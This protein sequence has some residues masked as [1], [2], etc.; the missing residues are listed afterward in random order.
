VCCGRPLYDFGL[1]DL[2]RR[3]LRRTLDALAEPL[4]AGVPVLVLE[5]SCAAVFRDEL[6]KLLPDDERARRLVASTVTIDELLSR[7]APDWESPRLSGRA[8]MHAHCHHRAVIGIDGEQRLLEDLGL[9]LQPL[10]VGC[11]GMAGSFGY[12]AG[13]PYLLSVAVGERALLPAIRAAGEETTLI[14][15]G[16]SCRTQIKD[17]TGRRAL[18]TAQVLRRGLPQS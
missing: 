2:A 17:G 8:M 6:R 9:D 13:E 18:H 7:H 11:C 14:A 15:D 1:L 3:T 12:E 5:P 10:P 4:G 16:F